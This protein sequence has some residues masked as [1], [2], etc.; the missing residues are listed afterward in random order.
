[1]TITPDSTPTTATTRLDRRT[2]LRGS[3]TLAALVLAGLPAARTA[4]QGTPGTTDAAT[5]AVVESGYAPVNGLDLYYEIHGAPGPAGT[6][7][8]LMLHGGFATVELMFGTLLPALAQGRQVIAAEL[9]GHGHTADSDRPL[10]F[11]TMADDIA[12]LLDHLAIPRVDLFGYSLG[13]GVGLRTAIQHPA[14]IRKLVLLSTVFRRDGWAPEALAGMSGLNAAAAVAMEATPLYDAYVRVAPRPEDW[15]RLVE[16]MGIF[17]AEDY[18]WTTE[19]AALTQPAQIVVGD[20]DSV[21]LGHAIEHFTL[22]G[23]GVPGDFGPLPASELA[24]LP[25]TAHSA[26]TFRADL[27]LPIVPPFLALAIENG[28]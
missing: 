18:D 13:G 23:G 26:I 11:E 3:A 25:R 19:V 9:Q 6:T 10:G 2:V 27:L 4:A 12:A 14:L 28:A 8:L 15:P 22:R 20:S 5:P 1:M 7:P 16:K 21:L 17:L 24:I